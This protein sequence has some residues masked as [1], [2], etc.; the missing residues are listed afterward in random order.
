MPKARYIQCIMIMLI[1][2]LFLS[3]ASAQSTTASLS[4][5]VVD[6]N[7]EVIPGATVTIANPSTG[8]T[9]ETTTNNNGVY[10]FPSLS[11]DTYTITAQG[12]SFSATEVKDVVLNVNDRR[13]L[14]IQLKVGDIGATVQVTAE[15]S[16]LI[17]ESPT[18]STVIDREFV[19]NLP[20]PGRSFQ[21]L[22]QL[23]PGVVITETSLQDQGQFSVNGQ[24]HSC[25][26][27][28][29]DGVSANF[30]GASGANFGQQAGGSLPAFSSQG[31]TNS[32]VS[33]D[34]LQEFTIQTSTYAA[35]FGRQPGAQISILTR[36]GTNDFHG[37]VFEYFRDEAL[38]ANDWF[39]NRA[40]LAKPPLSLH[41]FGGTIG[42]HVPLPNFGEGGPAFL[43]GKDRTFF[44]FSYEGLRLNQ[45]QT[46]IT[47]VPTVAA[48]AAAPAILQPFYNAYPLPNGPVNPLDPN[49][50]VF[51]ASFSEPSDQNTYSIRIDHNVNKRLQIFGRYNDST[52]NN[53]QRA[54][55]GQDQLAASS[56]FDTDFITRTL[57]LGAISPFTS[58]LVNDFRF[59]YSTNQT[60]ATAK[61][62]NFG[63][64]VPFNISD[65]FA[66]T[67]PAS[68]ENGLFAF[69]LFGGARQTGLFT[70]KNTTNTQK[71]INIVDHLSIVSGNHNLKFGVDYRRLSPTFA[72]RDY[73]AVVFFN[74]FTSAL[75]NLPAITGTQQSKQGDFFFN[76][77]GFY[78]QDTWKATPRLTLTYGLRYDLDFTPTLGGGDRL[79]RLPAPGLTISRSLL[80]HRREHRSTR[81][82][83]TT[84]HRASGSPINF[85]RS[86]VRRQYC[87]EAS[88]FSTIWRAKTPVK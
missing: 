4:G 16:S 41:Q 51:N 15:N 52:G 40:G 49:T 56:F 29:V 82:H 68:E 65:L 22:I 11:P 75:Q 6:P 59:N 57:T 2:L 67:P 12:G 64:A 42:G 53:I 78:A 23:S 60:V 55:P 50:A 31:G 32:L 28:Y 83:I 44:F 7:G 81:L 13:S 17:D 38:D 77:L 19:E 5:T 37:T 20:L 66:G 8:F 63:G 25:N 45:P 69:A 46:R 85:G 43:S 74:D 88:V 21:G 26:A 79:L 14:K 87:A 24:R 76:N 30:G 48:R 39:N 9:R 54:V 84:L 47:D 73:V 80:R 36:S 62:D 58:K 70:G 86:P 71:Q 61:L 10:T 18:V 72:P 33:V 35:E 1:C 34:A 3:N 27:F